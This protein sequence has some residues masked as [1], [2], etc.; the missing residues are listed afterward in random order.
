M[1]LQASLKV[2]VHIPFFARTAQIRFVSN[3]SPNN[4]SLC[5]GSRADAQLSRSAPTVDISSGAWM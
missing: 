5:L 1:P 4:S 2:Q 3:E